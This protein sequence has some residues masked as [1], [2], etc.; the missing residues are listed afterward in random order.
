MNDI[1]RG[2]AVL[3]AVAHLI[4]R[5]ALDEMSNVEVWDKARVMVADGWVDES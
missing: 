3:A 1:E 2:Y 4:E 5:G